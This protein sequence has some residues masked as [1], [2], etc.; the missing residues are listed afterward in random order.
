MA[1]NET[2]A[3]II[4]KLRQQLEQARQDYKELMNTPARVP[5]TPAQILC[6]NED[7]QCYSFGHSVADAVD[8][9][10]GTHDTVDLDEITFYEVT[11]IQ[12][13]IHYTIKR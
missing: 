3:Q 1:N 5:T 6:I 2:A 10:E 8:T 12:V 13:E 7:K 4:S 11:P 9:Y